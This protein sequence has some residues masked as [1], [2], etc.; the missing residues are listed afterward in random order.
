MVDSHLAFLHFPFFWISLSITDFFDPLSSLLPSSQS[1]SMRPL[2]M[3]G[4]TVQQR[5]IA[6]FLS[7]RQ[8]LIIFLLFFFLPNN[9]DFFPIGRFSLQGLTLLPINDQPFVDS[10]RPVFV[11]VLPLWIVHH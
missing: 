3:G 8:M 6:G 10:Y 1:S 4:V 7:T 2:F 9:F 11:L 5:L